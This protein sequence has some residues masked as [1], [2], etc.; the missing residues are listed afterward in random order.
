MQRLE[1]LAKSVAESYGLL[2]QGNLRALRSY[3]KTTSEEDLVKEI[4]SIGEAVLLRAL[5]E[6][7]LSSEL[8]NAVLKRLEKLS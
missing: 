1:R 2:H 4:E 8:Q 7:G 3:I 5:W 6:A